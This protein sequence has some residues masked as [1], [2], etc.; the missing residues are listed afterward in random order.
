MQDLCTSTE[1]LVENFNQSM[2]EIDNT[3]KAAVIKSFMAGDTQTAE[4][5]RTVNQHV[6]NLDKATQVYLD[7]LGDLVNSWEISSNNQNQ[8]H[9]EVISQLENKI[10]VLSDDVINRN[11]SI[12]DLEI[13]L[14][15]LQPDPVA[16]EMA[17]DDL[18]SNV[19]LNIT[20]L[21]KETFGEDVEVAVLPLKEV[22]YK[23][24]G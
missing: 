15:A 2:T 7:N 16:D 18:L 14:D 21:L 13:Q 8:A 19:P 4:E 22:L 1:L 24:A 11:N 10:R 23:P 12:I 5:F 9:E 17:F 20:D 6:Q 3:I